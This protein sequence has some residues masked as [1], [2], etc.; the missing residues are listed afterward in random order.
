MPFMTVSPSDVLG[1]MFTDLRLGMRGL[2]VF[3]PVGVEELPVEK[4][5]YI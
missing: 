1:S 5:Q 3:L 4:G 2:V